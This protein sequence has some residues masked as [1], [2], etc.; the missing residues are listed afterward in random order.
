MLCPNLGHCG[1][2]TAQNPCNA[3]YG[4]ETTASIWKEYVEGQS[5]SSS[6][7]FQEHLAPHAVSYSRVLETG[8]DIPQPSSALYQNVMVFLHFWITQKS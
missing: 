3:D 6:C 8:Q 5:T 4:L 2:Q 7:L 1:S